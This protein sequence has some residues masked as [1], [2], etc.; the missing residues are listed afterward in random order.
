M[1]ALAQLD[2]NRNGFRKA[3]LI[4]LPL[5]T[6]HVR[7]NQTDEAGGEEAPAEESMAEEAPAEEGMAEEGAAEEEWVWYDYTQWG[8]RSWSLAAAGAVG[9]YLLVA[10]DNDD[11]APAGGP[12]EEECEGI[13]DPITG[14]CVPL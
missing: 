12:P 7:V 5:V 6:R 10:D 3:S 9:V 14:E 11:P 1:P 2:F 13:E 4:G 8:W